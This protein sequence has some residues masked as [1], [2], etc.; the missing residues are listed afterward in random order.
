LA[1]FLTAI[2]ANIATP[3]TAMP[4]MLT[5]LSFDG[6]M[7]RE[8]WR[9]REEKR[10]G[11]VFCECF[12]IYL[13]GKTDVEVEECGWELEKVVSW[14]CGELE[15]ALDGVLV[16]GSEVKKNGEWVDFVVSGRKCLTRLFER[17][18]RMGFCGKEEFVFKHFRV[19]GVGAGGVEGSDMR[20]E[21]V[22]YCGLFR[23][24]KVARVLDGLYFCVPFETRYQIFQALLD[25]DRRVS[26]D[27]FMEARMA[28]GVMHGPPGVQIEVRRGDVFEDSFRQLNGLGEGLRGRIQVSFVNEH[29]VSEAG[30]DGG[31]VFKEFVDEIVK[32]CFLE[33]DAF[34]S[35][36]EHY[37]KVNPGAAAGELMFLGRILAKAVYESILVEPQ[38]S[39]PFLKKLLSTNNALDDLCLY[40]EELFTNLMKLKGME[41]GAIE[42]MG[43][44]FEAN[45]SVDRFGRYLGKEGTVELV[46]GGGGIEVTA[47]NVLQVSR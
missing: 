16:R 7:L 11:A 32:E 4:K 30:I 42:G 24:R 37:L 45:S 12:V 47:R 21:D 10:V 39:V 17:N 23:N 5:Q 33:R 3:R 44:F 31:G 2:L 35:T 46:E 38:F 25:A 14:L 1:S 34:V 28:A 22:D 6:A 29:G 18:E 40:D 9:G 27:E 19:A 36:P 8:L 26:Q 41:E 20:D 43:M 15:D 13:M